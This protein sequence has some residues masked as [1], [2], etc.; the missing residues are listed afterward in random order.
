MSGSSKVPSYHHF[1]N[2]VLEALHILGGSATVEELNDKV[3]ELAQ[4]TPEQLEIPHTDGRISEFEYRNAWARTYLKFFG[5]IDNSV[6]G[7]WSLTPKGRELGHV[8][9]DEVR[10][11]RRQEYRRQRK[12]RQEEVS[13]D[14]GED[15]L[16]SDWRDEVLIALLNM[17]PD[18]FER[19]AQRL[20]RE[21]GFIQVEV[22]GKS[23]DGGIDGRGIMRIGGMLNFRVM[24]QCKRYK[25]T[26]GASLIREFRGAVFGRADRGLLITTGNFTRDAIFEATRDGTLTIDLMDGDALVA[27]LKELSLGIKTEMVEQV[28]VDK[29]WFEGI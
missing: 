8:D 3:A 15:E 29:A 4:L 9:P 13:E 10:R 26:V 16:T 11:F 20:L 1:M 24:F 7:V 25:G 12:L 2:P 22:T 17:S 5:V 19:L 21:A 6:R 18:A 14:G 28:T 27:K 23:G